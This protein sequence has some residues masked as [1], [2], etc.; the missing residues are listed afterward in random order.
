MENAK[1][2]PFKDWPWWVKIIIL[3]T[4]KTIKPENNIRAVIMALLVIYFFL[5]YKPKVLSGN[6]E[7]LRIYLFMWVYISLM[8]LWQALATMWINKNSSRELI[9]NV[10]ILKR[11]LTIIL[12][13]IVI[14]IPIVI[15]VML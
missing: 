14:A 10:S 11:I 1:P 6:S 12:L 9:I 5:L 3:P 2:V 7:D 15:S 4:K 8:A 13:L